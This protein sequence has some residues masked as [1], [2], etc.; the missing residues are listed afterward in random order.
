[1]V[2]EY[3]YY[4]C[5]LQYIH[6]HLSKVQT[7]NSPDPERQP[8]VGDQEQ[9]LGCRSP[10]GKRTSAFPPGQVQSAPDDVL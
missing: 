7:I 3:V 8:L 10:A 9:I 4:V 6:R 1:M 5:N 2:I